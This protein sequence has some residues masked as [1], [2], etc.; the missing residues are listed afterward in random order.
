MSTDPKE[1]QMPAKFEPESFFEPHGGIMIWMFVVLELLVFLMAFGVY[2]AAKAKEPA[3]FSESQAHLS[4]VFATVNTLILIT[5]GYLLALAVRGYKSFSQ[6]VLGVL[7][8]SSAVLG[9][10]FLLIKFSE[11]KEKLTAGFH[12]GFNSFFEFYWVLTLFHA[13]HVILGVLLLLYYS[14]VFFKNEEIVKS[15]EGFS[16]AVIYWHMCDIIW[17][18]LFPI[19]YLL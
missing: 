3:L 18:L 13:A 1:V 12:I 4:Q 6:K 2:F 10:L 19:L 11:Y 9:V 5:S 14:Y 8:L 7:T 15:E 16:M 17:I